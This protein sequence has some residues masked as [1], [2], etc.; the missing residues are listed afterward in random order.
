MSGKC[1]IA[2]KKSKYPQVQNY[3]NPLW[4]LSVFLMG[5]KGLENIDWDYKTYC[6]KI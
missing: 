4:M 1:I 6:N 5:L 2:N 3:Q